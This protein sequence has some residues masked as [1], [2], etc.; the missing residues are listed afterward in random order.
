MSD[1]QEAFQKFTHEMAD[2][3]FICYEPLY[4][5]IMEHLGPSVYDNDA[6]KVACSDPGELKTVKENF[7]IKKLGL[8]DSEDLDRAVEQVCE[9]MGKSNTQK[10]RATFYYLLTGHFGKEHVFLGEPARRP[11]FND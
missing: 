8:E 10:H 4:H 1:Y 5:A 3:G 2:L 11:E 9:A 7:L 6:S